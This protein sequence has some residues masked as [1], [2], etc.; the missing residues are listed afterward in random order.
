V[1][2][3]E[4]EHF[5]A[6]DRAPDPRAV[7]SRNA[8]LV[9]ARDLLI[10]EGFSGV[11]HAAVATRSGVGRATLYRHWPDATNLVRD[12]L[13]HHIVVAPVEP[14]GN[15]RRDLF[16][17]LDASRAVLHEPAG[18]RA[19]RIIV[20]RASVDPKFA[21]VKD[22]LYR[23]ATHGLRVVLTDAVARR[24]LP[25]SLDIGLA[26]DQL[27]GPLFFRRLVAHRTFTSAY[28]RH[29]VEDFLRAHPERRR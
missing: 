18:D 5:P 29:I 15:L 19:L 28:V 1:A 13:V 4:G 3:I 25:A 17:A 8:A 6:P 12:T 7:R 22:L 14:T 26:A 27:L 16:A 24:E 20:E 21:Q 9:A 23:S 10:E 11:T 2:A